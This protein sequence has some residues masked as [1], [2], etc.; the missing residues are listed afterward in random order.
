MKTAAHEGPRRA[1]LRRLGALAT[2][3]ALGPLAG[4]VQA[5]GYPT[6]PIKII[7]PYAPGGS[8]DLTARLIGKALSQQLGQPVVVEN[9]AGAGGLVGQEAV[10]RAKPDGYTLLFSSAGPLTVSPQIYSKI[11]YDPVKSF[12]PLMLVATQP[13]LLIVKPPLE[14][15]DVSGL[16]ALAKA[17]A[18]GQ[19]LVYGS[20]G[21]GSASHLAMESFKELTKTDLVHVPYRGSGPALIDLV[22]G[23]I[24]VMFDVFSTAAPLA[25]SGKV[26]PI[27]ITS[28][29]RSPQFPD[30][31]TMAEAGVKGFDAGTWFAVLGP[32]GLPRPIVEQLNRALNA[33]L[34]DKEVRDNLVSQGAEPR[35][36]SPDQLRDFFDVEYER[37]GKVIKA[38]HITAD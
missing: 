3:L 24:D 10:A 1:L 31:P 32:A 33:T 19:K 6:Q 38:A 29:A 14:V 34:A 4:A 36:G 2:A 13:L 25:K 27:A 12:D 35:G 8:T 11:P 37:W 16:I 15:R 26:R 5:Q 23:Q 28:A 9:R 20:F 7:V 22:G 17:R 18:S 30:V 21:N